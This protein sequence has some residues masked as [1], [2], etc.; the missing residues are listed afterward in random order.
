MI[1]DELLIKYII[2]YQVFSIKSNLSI[3]KKNEKYDN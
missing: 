2:W 1:L 3:K